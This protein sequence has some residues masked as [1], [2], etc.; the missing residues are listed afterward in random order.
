MKA[1]PNANDRMTIYRMHKQGIEPLI[2]E[3]TTKVRIE[4]VD[5]VIANIKNGT[6]KGPKELQRPVRAVD[7]AKAEVAQL[8]KELEALKNPELTSGQKA[9]ATRKANKEAAEAAEETP[10]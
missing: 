7:A 8:K 5:I 9:A 1:G 10:S 3:A 4:Q 6:F 2:I